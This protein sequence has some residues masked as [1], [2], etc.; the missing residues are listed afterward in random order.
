MMIFGLLWCTMFFGYH[1][2]VVCRP[3]DLSPD[4]RPKYWQMNN[5][6]PQLLAFPELG[7]KIHRLAPNL[8][9]YVP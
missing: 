6:T 8:L 3:I 5:E 2:E 7:A 4:K 1:A 9:G